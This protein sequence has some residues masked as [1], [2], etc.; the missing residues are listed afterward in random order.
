MHVAPAQ[1]VT[2]ITARRSA[3]RARTMVPTSRGDL[4]GPAAVDV[5]GQGMTTSLAGCSRKGCAAFAGMFFDSLLAVVDASPRCLL[6]CWCVS[7][8]NSSLPS[9]LLAQGRI[10]HQVSRSLKTNS[11][12]AAS[13][14]LLSLATHSGMT[15]IVVSRTL[16]A[17]KCC[18]VNVMPASDL[19]FVADPIP[20]TSF[21]GLAGSTQNLATHVFLMLSFLADVPAGCRGSFS[22]GMAACVENVPQHMT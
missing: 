18:I 20:S 3:G 19:P 11:A 17:C 4:H 16:I 6:V 21:A 2:T 1:S 10:Q 22:L 9:L 12:G 13:L 15:V 7:L 14:W 8:W 5:V